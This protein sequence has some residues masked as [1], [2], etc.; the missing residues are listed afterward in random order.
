M[1][2]RADMFVLGVFWCRNNRIRSQCQSRKLHGQY[3]VEIREWQTCK[4]KDSSQM[5]SISGRI[6]ASGGIESER[7]AEDWPGKAI[8][9]EEM[10]SIWIGEVLVLPPSWACKP[11]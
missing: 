8:N 1:V 4:I 5:G 10:K 6:V 9:S 2:E 7:E 3:R 11:S